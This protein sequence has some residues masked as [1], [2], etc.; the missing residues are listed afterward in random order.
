MSNGI[1]PFTHERS[2][3]NLSSLSIRGETPAICDASTGVNT[4]WRLQYDVY[5]YFLPEND[6]SERSLFISIQSVADVRGIMKNSKWVRNQELG[7]SHC[8]LAANFTVPMLFKIHFPDIFYNNKL[9]NINIKKKHS[10][11]QIKE[12]WQ[13]TCYQLTLTSS[14]SSP[15]L[16]V[17]T[18]SSTDQ[19][20]AVFN[21]IPGQGVVYS[22]IVRDPLLNTSASY[23]PVHTYACSFNSTVD[24]C[25]N[26]GGN[27]YASDALHDPPLVYHRSVYHSVSK[28]CDRTN[29]DCF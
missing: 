23:I 27:R 20:K 9:Q 5:Q 29:A 14:I 6:L 22:V 16:Q 15:L 28:S 12:V 1:K 4:R 24:G 11:W 19:T 26:L 25:E 18:L 2:L 10:K 13:L 8:C 7:H 21:S 3:C 17:M